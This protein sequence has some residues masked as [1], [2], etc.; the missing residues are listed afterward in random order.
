MFDRDDLMRL[1]VRE[2]R[3]WVKDAQL[4]RL[5][6]LEDRLDYPVTNVSID[7]KNYEKLK[8]YFGFERYFENNHG[9]RERLRQESC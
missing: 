7:F 8:E 5:R 9:E 2:F 3:D 4:A 1:D 6:R